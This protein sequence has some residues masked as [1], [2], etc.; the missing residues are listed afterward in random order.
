MVL[1]VAQSFNDTAY[2]LEVGQ[3]FRSFVVLNDVDYMLKAGVRLKSDTCYVSLI[4]I[5]TSQPT[6]YKRLLTIS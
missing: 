5:N 1:G 2:C 6:F 3:S 4:T